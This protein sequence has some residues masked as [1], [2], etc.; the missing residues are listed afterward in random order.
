MT[1]H[2]IPEIR[3]E[4]RCV[5]IACEGAR[6]MHEELARERAARIALEWKLIELAEANLSE[7]WAEETV[8][9]VRWTITVK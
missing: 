9:A 1:R 8:N 3:R 6:Q 7:G 5:E 4:L 2:P